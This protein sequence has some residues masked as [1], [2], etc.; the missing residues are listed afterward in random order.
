MPDTQIK[1]GKHDRVLA[2]IKAVKDQILKAVHALKLNVK[3]IHQEIRNIMAEIDDLNAKLDAQAQAISDFNTTLQNAVAAITTEIQQLAAAVQSATDL[4]ALK[5]QV[6]AAAG[7][8]QT[9]TDGIGAAGVT[10][11]GQIDALEADD[12]TATPATGAK[13]RR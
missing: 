2:A 13:R 11:Q 3:Q 1:R 6:T 10:L 7:R 5:V 9:A 8:V 12:P 4:A